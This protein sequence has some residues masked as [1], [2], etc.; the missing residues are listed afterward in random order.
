MKRGDRVCEEIARALRG[1]EYAQTAHTCYKAVIALVG[2]LRKGGVLCTDH[3]ARVQA[4]SS[5][6][7]RVCSAAVKTPSANSVVQFN[8]GIVRIYGVKRLLPVVVASYL[9]STTRYLGWHDM[10]GGKICRTSSA[11]VGGWVMKL[12]PWL[13]TIQGVRVAWRLLIICTRALGL[14]TWIADI[15]I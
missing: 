10:C 14:G 1:C 12:C 15:V 5:P 13:N 3:L 2:T 4:R 9:M 11:F 8:C 7:R 6:R